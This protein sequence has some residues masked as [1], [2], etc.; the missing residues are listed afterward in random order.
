GEPVRGARAGSESDEGEGL[1][2]DADRPRGPPLLVEAPLCL[3]LPG[4]GLRL[5][6]LANLLSIDP[7]PFDP[8]TYGEEGEAGSSAAW[9]TTVHWRWAS[10]PQGTIQRQSNAR[11]VR[12]SDG[13]LQLLLGADALDVREIDIAGEHSFVFARHQA[14]IQGQS[15]LDRKLVFHPASLRSRFHR[16]LAAALDGQGMRST[17]VRATTTLAD[18][19]KLKR[20]R[21]LLEEQR[22][23][24]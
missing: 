3:P 1:N 16:R 5:V 18:P 7:R 12:W 21:E 6:R 13:S 23:R 14:L 8:D 24:D 19:A 10:T 11:F 17:K 22:I 20:E 15:A 4:E 2:G 9:E